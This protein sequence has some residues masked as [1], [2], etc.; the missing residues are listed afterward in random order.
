MDKFFA[1]EFVAI[2]GASRDETKIGHGVLKNLL[3]A[4]FEG[5]LYPVNPKTDDILGLTC[6]KTIADIPGGIDLVM[7][8]VPSKFVMGIVEDMGKKKVPAAVIISAGF[9]ESG[10]NGAKLES[11]LLARTKALGIAVVGPNCLGII[12][13]HHKLNASFAAGTPKEGNIAFFS[14]SGALCTAILDWAKKESTI[15]AEPSELLDRQYR[16]FRRLYEQTKDIAAELSEP[17]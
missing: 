3:E 16:L 12:D 5:D 10:R 2:V 14:Q 9:K 6:Y 13:T 7:V 4:G 15:Q 1:P 17:I 11:E 8:I